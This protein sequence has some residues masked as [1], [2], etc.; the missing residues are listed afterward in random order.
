MTAVLK[1]RPGNRTYLGATVRDDGVNFA[2]ASTVADS[3]DVCLFDASGAETRFELDEYDEGP[4][5]VLNYG[6]CVGHALEAATEYAIPH[7]IAVMYGMAAANRLSARRGWI[8][9]DLCAEMNRL[10]EPRLPLRE[11]AARVDFDVMLSALRRDKKNIGG[12]LRLVLWR[13]IGQ[14]EIAADIDEHEV[15]AVLGRTHAGPMRGL[16]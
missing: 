16:G 9:S 15:R 7:G 4:R 14:A 12:R 11:V 8:S 1:A 2:V 5:L 13:G 6:H 10:S 3:V